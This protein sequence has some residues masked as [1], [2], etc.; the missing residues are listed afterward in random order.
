M[1]EKR[2]KQFV[3]HWHKEFSWGND[4]FKAGIPEP[5][6]H[7]ICGYE[8]ERKKLNYFVIEKQKILLLEGDEGTGKTTLIRWLKTQLE[9][10]R[11]ITLISLDN[12]LKREELI[13]EL[14]T[15]FLTLKEKLLIIG[16]SL[17]TR[18]IIDLVKDERLKNI[19]ESINF[20][21]IELDYN[22]FINFLKGITQDKQIMIIVDNIDRMS[23]EN[24]KIIESIINS[25][26]NFDFVISGNK[27]FL[28]KLHCNKPIKINLLGMEYE[29]CVDMIRKRIEG[30]GGH[31]LEPFKQDDLKSLYKKSGGNPVKFLEAAREKAIHISLNMI[32]F[33]KKQELHE[34]EDTAFEDKEENNKNKTYEIKIINQ[35]KH[36]IKLEPTKYK[37]DIIEPKKV[38]KEK[39]DVKKIK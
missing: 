23:P 11:N 7:F 34:N 19:I 6:D 22:K 21:N 10:Y 39:I 30:S 38:K 33:G 13:K 2:E 8:E 36:E 25:D 37:K 29:A 12:N 28:E 9:E 27:K 32:N 26:I 17:R 15:G 35:P 24:Y 16:S 31:D 4:P 5:I 14:I 3:Y 1:K 20:P 18:K